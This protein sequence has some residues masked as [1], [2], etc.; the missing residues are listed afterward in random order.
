MR[1][2]FSDNLTGP[3][4][5]NLRTPGA[6]RFVGLSLRT[7]TRHRMRP[8]REQLELFR[9][10]PGE[11]AHTMRRLVVYPFFSLAVKRRT[12]LGR[13]YCLTQRCYPQPPAAAQLATRAKRVERRVGLHPWTGYAVGDR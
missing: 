11:L 9:A 1:R 3:S 6:A 10:L 7:P 12:E 8:E 13:T 4:P 5:R 2:L